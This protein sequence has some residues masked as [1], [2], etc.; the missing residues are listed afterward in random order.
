[1]AEVKSLNDFHLSPRICLV[2][3]LFSMFISHL[4]QRCSISVFIV[5]IVKMGLTFRSCVV[6]DRQQHLL[7]GSDVQHL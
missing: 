1:M 4:K 7:K 2:F 6:T 3:V 5:I